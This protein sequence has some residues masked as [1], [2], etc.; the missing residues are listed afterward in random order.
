MKKLCIDFDELQKAIEDTE[1]DAFDYFLD[2][3][4]G[5]VVVLSAEIIERAE[6]ILAASYDE[7]IADF[8]D[9]E[10][11]ELPD[12]PEWM[13]DEI[14][15]ALEILMYEQGRYERIPERKPADA[16]AAMKEF[17]DTLDNREV[18]QM[19]LRVL[20][21]QGSFRKFKDIIGPFPKERKLWYRFNARASKKEI[22]EWLASIGISARSD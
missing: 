5:E 8:E 20:D 14:E 2:R 6:M 13:E 15:L 19:L 10:Q 1:R 22:A 12:I 9:V 4:T 7:D 3:E 11:E 16:Y 21:G 18:G 17:V